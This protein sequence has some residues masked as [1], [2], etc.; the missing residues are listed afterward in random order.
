[1]TI[2]ERINEA[3][4]NAIKQTYLGATLGVAVQYGLIAA[5]VGDEG[6]AG[7]D[8]H[9]IAE[10]LHRHALKSESAVPYPCTPSAKEREA[11]LIQEAQAARGCARRTRE[12]MRR[13]IR[14]LQAGAHEHQSGGGWLGP[15]SAVSALGMVASVCK[16]HKLMGLAE[17]ADDAQVRV[18]QQDS[19]YFLNAYIE[20]QEA[21][22][23]A[24]RIGVCPGCG[25]EF[26]VSLDIGTSL[27]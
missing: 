15:K 17:Q 18:Q 9:R 4:G 5:H 12:A 6:K 24:E 8:V 13:V 27:L 10:I 26:H 11:T 21:R 25:G 20:R 7:C 3:I 19:E 14:S 16:S 1:M 22:E 2:D 23:E